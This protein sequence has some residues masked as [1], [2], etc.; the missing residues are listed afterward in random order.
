MFYV[1][2]YS[3]CPKRAANLLFTPYHILVGGI[4]A[5]VNLLVA[6]V[7][8][9][10]KREPRYRYDIYSRTDS[11]RLLTEPIPAAPPGRTS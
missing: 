11:A 2:R 10:F 3:N 1:S 6:S 4:F 8:D 7:L 9:F 5:L